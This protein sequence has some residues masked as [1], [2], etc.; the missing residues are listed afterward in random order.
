MSVFAFFSEAFTKLRGIVK[1]S[2]EEKVSHANEPEDAEPRL[3]ATVIPSVMI[4][5]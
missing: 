4:F 1:N 2:N 5:H 3:Y